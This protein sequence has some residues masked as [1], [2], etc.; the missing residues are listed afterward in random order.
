MS[1]TIRL[2]QPK[3]FPLS[4]MT[5]LFERSGY[6]ALTFLLVL[7]IK[8]AYNITDN[9]AFILFGVFN[10]L[11]FLT[12]AVGGYL[13]DN[14]L[15]IRRTMLLGLSIETIGMLCLAIPREDLL[16]F[17]LSCVIVGVGLFKVGPTDLMG[18]SYHKED[19][20]IDS[21]F[22]LYYMMMNI[23]AFFSPIAMGYLQR[24]FGWHVAFLFGAVVLFL[25]VIIFLCLRHRADEFEVEAGRKKLPKKSILMLV[26]GIVSACAISML[27]LNYT[28]LANVTF[29]MATAG[30]LIYFANEIRKSPRKEKL[31]IIACLALIFI[32]M[33]FFIMYFQLFMSMTLFIKR[34]VSHQVFGFDIP[35][36]AFLALNNFWVVALSPLLVVIYN[37]LA[38]SN[39]DMAITNKFALG[40]F[41]TS[42]C[43]ISLYIST[44]FPNSNWQVS[45]LWIV[46]A[47]M[48]Y[49]L[50]ELLVSALGVAMVTKIA[51]K[52]MYGVMMGAWF[53]IASSLASAVSSSVASFASVPD[54]LT[55]GS[56][57]LAIYNKA[58]FEMGLVGIIGS[59]V[60]FIVGP[61]I[62]RMANLK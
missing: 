34:S 20:R 32:G 24:Y 17:A 40:I 8:S 60:V 50:G 25:G 21:G 41:I 56:A 54:T 28:M 26:L 10:A 42:L 14:V 49:S 12:P 48:L 2:K 53:L 62:K 39:K 6:Y 52:R 37:R 16:Y 18:R 36:S 46:L 51:P 38:K 19:P 44:F 55:D 45:S 35:P 33:L 57:I 43:F 27:L 47:I 5:A 7:Y 29:A 4:V 9:N 23:G 22:T 13:A 11:V 61:Y 58:F 1:H 15:G 30:L 31:E 3:V 59:I